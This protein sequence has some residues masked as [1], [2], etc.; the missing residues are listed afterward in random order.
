MS[1][2]SK[3]LASESAV[4]SVRN[5]EES[6]SEIVVGNDV[7][8]GQYKN[9]IDF[10]FSMVSYAVGLGN[11]WRFPYLC[12]KNGGGTFIVAYIF[13]FVFATLPVF[14]MEVSVGQYLQRGA[15][16]MW[17]IVPIFKG[18]GLA[19]IVVSGMCVWY[20]SVV[21]TWAL[22]FMIASCRTTFPWESCENWWN[23]ITP[24]IDVR[25]DRITACLRNKIATIEQINE[26]VLP[27]QTSV[28]QYWDYRVTHATESIFNFGGMQWE[29]FG[30]HAITWL[31]IYFAIWKGITNANKFIYF[32]ATF[33]YV[34]IIILMGRSLTLDGALDGIK[35]YITPDLERFISLSLWRDAATQVFFSCGVGFGTLIALGSRN[36]FTHPCYRDVIL[37]CCIDGL[38]S[39]MAGF[40]IFA[41]L[42]YMAYTSCKPV[43]EVVKQGPALAFL[44]YPEAAT[45]LPLKQL[46]AV[47]FFFMLIIL[48]LDTLVCLVEGLY[49]AL[50]DRYPNPLRTRKPWCMLAFCTFFYVIGT[51]MSTYAG[52]HWVTLVDQYGATGYALMFSV[53]FE[54][55]GISWG[56]GAERVLHGLGDMLGKVPCYGWVIAWKYVT[57]LVTAILFVMSCIFYEPL[58]YPDNRPYEAGAEALGW[59][60]CLA[61]MLMVPGWAIYYLVYSIFFKYNRYSWGERIRRAVCFRKKIVLAEGIKALR[62]EAESVKSEEQTAT[63]SDQ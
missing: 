44:A 20:Y 5:E 38:T 22:H 34:I 41:I 45:H 21:V 11:V 50:E 13:C 56:F 37:T 47:L 6:C 4:V 32:C 58:H 63:E 19:N 27:S 8:R 35:Y 7:D 17:N 55:V 26:T 15:M 24:C 9:S 30:L 33:P 25:T 49:T 57:P 53:F 31:S 10:L 40:P 16:E 61:S 12:F 3:T 60:I 36:K 62:E 18:V 51:P 54:V 59:V 52:L 2:K 39:F 1:K 48:G 46:W 43:A 29:I 14:L 28:E 42:G 23:S